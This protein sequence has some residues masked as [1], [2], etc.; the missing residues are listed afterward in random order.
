M[1]HKLKKKS[2][3]RHFE[4]AFSFVWRKNNTSQLYG[5]L[6]CDEKWILHDN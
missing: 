1:P 2:K 4:V 6:T 3:N 5:M